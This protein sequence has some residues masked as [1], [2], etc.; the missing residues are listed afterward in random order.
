MLHRWR[1]NGDRS[2]RDYNCSSLV[3]I[4]PV[5]PYCVIFVVGPNFTRELEYLDLLKYP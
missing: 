4:S 1:T 2:K 5:F 3:S